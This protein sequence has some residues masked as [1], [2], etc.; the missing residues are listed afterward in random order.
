[1]SY[2]IVGIMFEIY[3]ELGYGYQEKHYERAAEKI[4][5]ERKID[6][7]KQ[8]RHNIIFHNEKIGTYYF[9]FLIEDKIIVELKKGNYFSRKNIIQVKEYLSAVGLKL[10]LIINFTPYGVKTLRILN[11]NNK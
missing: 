3:N 9:D 1:M 2:K 8:L 4:F 11:P 10:A 6:Y 7:K 5:I